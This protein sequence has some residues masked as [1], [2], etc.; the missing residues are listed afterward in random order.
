MVYVVRG[1]IWAALAIGLMTMTG[2]A[3]WKAAIHSPN[4]YPDAIYYPWGYEPA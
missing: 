1:W 3:Q 2:C 4:R